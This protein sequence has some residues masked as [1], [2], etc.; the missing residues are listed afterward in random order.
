MPLGLGI[1]EVR[2]TQKRAR[3]PKIPNPFLSNTAIYFPKLIFHNSQSCV[4]FDYNI[5]QWFKSGLEISFAQR[6]T[7][8][9]SQI[10]SHQHN[11]K[12]QSNHP[13]NFRF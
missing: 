6:I 7:N 1:A 2:L 3:Y 13:L 12:R 4:T 5:T 11:A 8:H 9:K 10:T